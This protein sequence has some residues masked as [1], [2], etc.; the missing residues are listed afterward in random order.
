MSQYPVCAM[1][2]EGENAVR[3]GRALIGATIP[4]S[5]AP[6]TLRG[7]FALVRQSLASKDVELIILQD[8]TRNVCHGSDTIESAKREV[9]IWFEEDEI[10][11]WASSG[12]TG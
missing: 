4:S 1:V 8:I 5:S 12:M 11:L 3:I 6:G 2:W 9:R 10:V 7:D